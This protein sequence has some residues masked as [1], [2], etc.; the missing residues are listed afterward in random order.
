MGQPAHCLTSFTSQCS[1]QPSSFTP[2][3][4]ETIHTSRLMPAFGLETGPA[5][6]IVL[7]VTSAIYLILVFA[8]RLFLRLKVNGPFGKDDWACAIST[9]F[10]LFYSVIVVVQVFLGLGFRPRH[11]SSAEKNNLAIIGWVNG[12]LL[13]F[14]GYFSKISACFLLARITRTREHLAVAYALMVAMTMWLIQAQV[15]AVF[16]CSYPHPWDTSS[17][18]H[19]HNRVSSLLP[20]P[21]LQDLFL[22]LLLSSGAIGSPLPCFPGSW[23][24]PSSLAQSD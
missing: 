14:A 2:L 7:A 1:P 23:S 21:H 11:L 24:S 13:T 10:G 17:R 16:Q 15:S 20:G 5:Y 9:V 18:N 19:C 6:L 22:S 8:I 4:N 12:F 3:G